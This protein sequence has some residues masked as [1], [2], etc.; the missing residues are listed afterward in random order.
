MA[1]AVNK[2]TLIWIAELSA[3]NSCI[4]A[5]PTV[6]TYS[7]PLVV[8][9]HLHT[10]SVWRCPSTSKPNVSMNTTWKIRNLLQLVH[11]EIDNGEI[12]HN[13]NKIFVKW[14]YRVT[15]TLHIIIWHQ[16]W[17]PHLTI[18]ELKNSYF[19]LT[20]AYRIALHASIIRVV[21]IS[22]MVVKRAV[23]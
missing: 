10:T 8:Q 1:N 17:L 7:P 13:N 16:Y 19:S 5:G 21:T 22:S 23:Y 6:I 15:G 14:G 3:C 2:L 12:C 20:S 9:T 4:I 11:L 18:N